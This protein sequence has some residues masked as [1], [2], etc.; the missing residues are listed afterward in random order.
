MRQADKNVA[1]ELAAFL[2]SHNCCSTEEIIS[3]SEAL[4]KIIAEYKSRLSESGRL[5]NVLVTTG[6]RPVAE[7][8]SFRG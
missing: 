5:P 4:K 1:L 8:M 2:Q 3:G 6:L 7:N